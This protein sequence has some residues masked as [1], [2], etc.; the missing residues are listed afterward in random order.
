MDLS[1]LI[2]Y[3]SSDVNIKIKHNE[4]ILDKI[5]TLAL[6]DTKCKGIKKDYI[7]DQLKERESQGSTGVG[8]GVA[9][10]H[11]RIKGMKDF[12]IMI[13]TNKGVDY[14]AFDNK[15]VKLFFVILGPE[16]DVNQHLQI[17]AALAGHIKVLKRELLAARKKDALVEIFKRGTLEDSTISTNESINKKLII[18]T[19]YIEDYLYPILEYF[20]Q[21]DIEGA[22]I[23]E[24]AGM[25][26][27]ISDIPLFATFIGFM[28]S[29]KNSSKTIIAMIPED[30]EEKII[31]GIED[32]TGDLNKK[33]GAMIITLDVSFYKGSMKIL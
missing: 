12:M 6:K 27:Y 19:L 28:N 22:S 3:E 8:D 30:K 4:N 29:D 7:I 31:S 9:I 10:P 1:K 23:I 14:G 21:E 24:S 32:I 33:E 18:I 26:Q 13:I 11:A 20:I 2:S 15:K 17:L 16:E 25:G 5:G